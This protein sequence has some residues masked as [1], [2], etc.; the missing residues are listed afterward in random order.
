MTT[1][2]EVRARF[3]RDRGL[4]FADS[5]SELSILD[6]LNEH[7]VRFRDRLFSPATTIWGFLS[8]V[9]SDDHSC[10]DAVSRVIAHRAASGLG[11]CSPNTAS[12][13]NARARLPTAV[14]RTLARRTAQQLQDGLPV[15][16]KWNGRDV[17]IADG[18]HVSMPD[19]EENQA[20][21]PQPAVQ[22]PG[23]GFPLARLA[24]LLSLASGAC[25]DLA[26]APYAGKGTGETTLLRQMYDTLQP[27]DVVLADALFDDYFLACELRQRG[28]DLVA[29]AQYQRVGSQ[30]VES[31]PDGD[32][33]LWRRPNKPHGMS[34]EQYRRYPETLLMRQVTVD[35][36]GKDNRV[37]QFKVITTILDASIDGREIGELYERRW[38]GEVDIRSIKSTMKMDIL[39]CK[40]P[41]MVR[42]EIWAHL[43]G[44][45]LLRAVMAVAA[46]ESRVEPRQISFKG[47][48]QALTA[49]APKLEAARP[50]QRAG[51]VD[52]MLEAVAYHRVGNRPGRWEPRARK[53]RPKPGA[54]LTQP[55]A[56]ARLR[57]NRSKWF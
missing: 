30:T 26:I 17:F 56:K 46:S 41:E 9:L 54:R 31:R 5:L 21:Y 33:I 50:Q 8:Q 48:K 12:Y 18:S 28:I 52:A 38:Q 32:I 39:R 16:W 10:R 55:R 35:A 3:A 29:R 42:K 47:A 11:P 7:G 6:A 43:L 57:R 45:N 22:Q 2:Q 4:P 40:T 51:L 13:C 27:G 14:L 25:C 19:T 49:F 37:E 15:G 53:R 23:I 20:G 1:L 44:Y 36:R 34:G 24:V